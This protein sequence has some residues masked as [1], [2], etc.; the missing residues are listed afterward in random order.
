MKIVSHREL[1]TRAEAPRCRPFSP[2]PISQS[3]PHSWVGVP[4]HLRTQEVAQL[5]LAQIPLERMAEVP[6]GDLK[7]NTTFHGGEP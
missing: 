5:I 7:G 2:L 6:L 4:G 1:A 3:C